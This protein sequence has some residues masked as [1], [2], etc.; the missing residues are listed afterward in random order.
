M[1]TG[2]PSVFAAR[3]SSERSRDSETLL[4]AVASFF[5]GFGLLLLI[6]HD[7][8]FIWDDWWWIPRGAILGQ[9]KNGWML[10]FICEE[11]AV[12]GVHQCS[13][14][15]GF[16]YRPLDSLLYYVLYTFSGYNPF[17]YHVAKS[18]VHGALTL[19][20]FLLM[21]EIVSSNRFAFLSSVFY[22]L[23]GSAVYSSM[24]MANFE[25]TAE[26]FFIFG[27]FLFVRYISFKDSRRTSVTLLCGIF[28]ATVLG[29]FFKDTG[30]GLPLVIAL[31]ALLFM[32]SKMTRG[33]IICLAA[34]LF[35]VAFPSLIPVLLLTG[36]IALNPFGV[37]TSFGS[38]LSYDVGVMSQNA[39]HNFLF[40]M[41]QVGTLTTVLGLSS[42]IMLRKKSLALVAF[43]ASWFFA[44][45]IPTMIASAPRLDLVLAPATAIIAAALTLAYC[46]LSQKNMRR[47]SCHLLIVLLI[48][49]L[50]FQA[51]SAWSTNQVWGTYWRE[52]KAAQEWL[53]A[54]V[55]S[56]TVVYDTAVGE[57]EFA[58]P[59]HNVTYTDYVGVINSGTP[60]IYACVR[61]NYELQKYVSAHKEHFQLVYQHSTRVF[62]ANL[63]P[64]RILLGILGLDPAGTYRPFSF[65][66]EF[67]VKCYL[68]VDQSPL[69]AVT[70]P[71]LSTHPSVGSASITPL[72]LRFGSC[73]VTSNSEC[74]GAIP[75]P[76]TCQAH[77]MLQAA[78]RVTEAFRIT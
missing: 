70:E 29:S 9:V 27:L 19:A 72:Q 59:F 65:E 18:I 33:L 56:G 64:G 37:S 4:F 63:D 1:S 38:Y 50:L 13:G 39:V 68:K 41:V 45:Y 40:I 8:G 47:T 36:R 28:L 24:W 71:S 44:T 11:P 60:P 16:G 74:C 67:G 48:G 54:N 34:S 31:Y 75:L 12:R 25:T 42:L 76:H 69:Q 7:L 55:K 78:N 21:R 5:F 52:G 73:T 14:S 2:P 61:A 43:P 35:F 20:F 15:Y 3:L 6:S 49:S 51:S 46:C 22:S 77:N 23:T 62:Y 32:R 17:A 57:M 10:S 58:D 30:K 26:V 53:F 66:Q